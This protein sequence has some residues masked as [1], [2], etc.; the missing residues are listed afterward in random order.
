MSLGEKN[1]GKENL[2]PKPLSYPYLQK[3]DPKEGQYRKI[4]TLFNNLQVVI[5]FS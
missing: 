5:P 3:K 4:F 2:A 1:K